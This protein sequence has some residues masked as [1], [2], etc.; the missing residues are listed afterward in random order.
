MEPLT[1]EQL[2]L[3]K[4]MLERRIE[5]LSRVEQPPQDTSELP[6]DE[7][8]TSPLDRATVRLLNDLSREAADHHSAEMRQLRQAL[9][10]FEDGT[11]GLCE[12]C[13]QP[14][15]ASRLLARPEARLCIDCQTRAERR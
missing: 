14:I 9:A 7:V 8:E 12:E 5:A 11:Y 10:R 3:L 1:P 13:G 2:A 4:T 15:G 6:V